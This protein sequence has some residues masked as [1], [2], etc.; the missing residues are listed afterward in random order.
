MFPA[1][2]GE[3]AR[4]F[5]VSYAVGG[6]RSVWEEKPEAEKT[7][8]TKLASW[9]AKANVEIEKAALR[10]TAFVRSLA[11]QQS[12]GQSGVDAAAAIAGDVSWSVV[13]P[14]SSCI[15]SQWC[16]CS[17]RWQAMAIFACGQ[18]A[19]TS[20]IAAGAS[21][22][23]MAVMENQRRIKEPALYAWRLSQLNSLPAQKV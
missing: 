15:V 16:A 10:A 19:A 4:P 8:L 23:Q 17:V 21:K 20:G 14:V 1:K 13:P 5:G 9:P 12:I 6:P 2:K 7:G 3:R 22:A 11:E 18:E